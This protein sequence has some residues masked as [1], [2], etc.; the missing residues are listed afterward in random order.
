MESRVKNAIEKD[1]PYGLFGLFATVTLSQSIRPWTST[2][3]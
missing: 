3:L 1:G 2:K